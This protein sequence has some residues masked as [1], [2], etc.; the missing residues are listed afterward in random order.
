MNKRLARMQLLKRLLSSISEGRGVSASIVLTLKQGE[1]AEKL[2]ARRVL[3]GFPP[4]KSMAPV[5]FDESKE[6]GMLASLVTL[7]SASNA[8]TVGKKGEELSNLL[9]R[10]LKASEEKAMEARVFQMRGLIMSA[11]LGGLMAVVSAVGPLMASTDFLAGGAF[12]AG[13]SL[14]LV[15]AAMVAVSS[16]MLGIFLSGRRFYVNLALALGV[17]LVASFAASPLGSIAGFGAWG[18]K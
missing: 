7:A 14:S 9:E 18:I 16:S 17:Y 1:G 10:W 12:T 11:V 13:P 2:A 3:L 6:L 4:D 5:V 15:S 8:A